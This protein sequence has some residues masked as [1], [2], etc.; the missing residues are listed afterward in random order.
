M[1]PSARIA[2]RRLTLPFRLAPREK[3]TGGQKTP[4]SGRLVIVCF[5]SLS[6]P[7]FGGRF[8]I[9]YFFLQGKP[10]GR[11]THLLLFFGGG[12]T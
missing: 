9:I 8:F 5:W 2:E 4:A 6:H 3:E 11:T 7:V 10:E 12:P 1:T